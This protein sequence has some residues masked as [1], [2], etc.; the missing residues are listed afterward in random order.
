[1]VDA[2]NKNTEAA[3]PVFRKYPGNQTYFK[4]FSHDYFE[5]IRRMGDNYEEHAYQ[6]S[7][8][9]D[10]NLIE[11]MIQLNGQYWEEAS[12][13]EYEAFKKHCE[14]QLTRLQ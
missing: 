12:K 8:L 3:F 11:D 13:K 10:R 7:I 5:E 9:P 14:Q 6:A 2:A 1:M 4:I